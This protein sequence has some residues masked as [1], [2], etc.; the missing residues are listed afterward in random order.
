MVVG[1]KGR[2]LKK[3]TYAFFVAK[4][5]DLLAPDGELRFICS[6]TFL[7]I[8]TMSG[9][10]LKLMDTCHT[11]VSKIQYFSDEISYPL[12][13]LKAVKRSGSRMTVFGSPLSRQ[14][15]ELTDNLSWGI[16]SEYSSLFIGP[17]VGDYVVASSGMTIGANELF[18]KEV[19]NGAILEDKSYEF[20]Q[21]PITLSKELERA[22]L[23]KLSASKVREIKHLEA[24]G[25]TR[26]NLRVRS[27][28]RP[29]SVTLPHP[30]YCFYNKSSAHRWYSSP[31]TAI[32]WKDDGDA[33]LTYKKNGRWYLHGVGGAKFFKKEGLTW[34]LVS[35]S[36]K[37]RY[38]PPG[39]IL[40]SGSPV[41]I[42]RPGVEVEELYFILAWLNTDLCTRVLKTVINHTRN[43]Q[44]K[45]VERLPYPFWVEQDVKSEIILLA[46]CMVHSLVSGVD[47]RFGESCLTNILNEMFTPGAGELL[48]AAQS[49][50]NP[51]P[52]RQLPLF[53]AA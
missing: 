35:S 46:K 53:D 49:N 7:T 9:L 26:R 24:D 32:Y 37:V 39:Y 11:D 28:D 12:V 34:P 16:C 14:T 27:L 30:D 36:L 23:N 50:V 48:G 42:L 19:V 8:S 3:D 45:D 6:D 43:I 20:F 25:A 15:V 18:L 10:R 31:S 4:C 52:T 22:R 47:P 21:E 29:F 5:I 38:L 33:V 51:S 44:G 13:L 41:A 1:W 17:K 2:K 40:D